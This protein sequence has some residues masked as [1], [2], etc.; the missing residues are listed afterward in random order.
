MQLDVTCSDVI[1]R[2]AR[3]GGMTMTVQASWHG[4]AAAYVRTKF[5]NQSPAVYQRLR[6]ENG[7]M[8]R[9]HARALPPGP[10]FTPELVGRQCGTDVVLAAAPDLAPD[11]WFLRA[12]LD[13]PILFD[14][15]VDH[16]PGMLLLEAARQAALARSPRTAS[17]IGMTTRFIRYTEFDVPCHV[18][19]APLA[20]GAD[21]QDGTQ[22]VQ[23]TLS[24]NDRPVFTADV[25]TALV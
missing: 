24:Q 3:V 6:G 7:D 18:S 1:R 22:V 10:P 19:A 12:D 13:H 9:A 2:G 5:N 25:T 15:P 23:V 16:A 8:A 4:L 17:V 20:P 11:H 14:H 21:S